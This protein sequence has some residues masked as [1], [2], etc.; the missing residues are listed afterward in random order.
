[1]VCRRKQSDGVTW[2]A[3]S[4]R[5]MPP[6]GLKGL[7]VLARS[8]VAASPFVA[9]WRKNRCVWW[10][11]QAQEPLLGGEKLGRLCLDRSHQLR[12]DESD[13]EDASRKETCTHRLQEALNGLPMKEVPLPRGFFECFLDERGAMGK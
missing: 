3:G 7:T 4:S 10:R 9:G 5:L 11:K 1:M 12:C 6:R 2:Q 8:V 13:M